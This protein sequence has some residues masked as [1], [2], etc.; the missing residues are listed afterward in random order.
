MACANLALHFRILIMSVMIFAATFCVG[1]TDP[2][3]VAAIN[4]LYVALGS[5]PLQGWK[6]TGGDPCVEQWQGVSCVFSNI[7]ALQ[8]G[9]MNLSGQLGSNL[10]FPSIIEMDI[11][12][13]SIG[14]TI[15]STLPSTLKRLSLSE[16]K[17]NGSIPDALSMLIQLTELS[18]NNNHLTGQIPDVFLQF[19]SLTNMNLS[20]NN[21]SG[22]LPPSIV[23]LSSLTTLHLQN[24]QLGGTLF[25]LEDL[26]L[27]NL[28]IENNL[29]SG[30]IPPK[31]LTIPEFRK[32]GNPFNTTIIHSPPA[33]APSPEAMVPSPSP[34]PSTEKSHGKGA[35]SPSM[36][37]KAP[38]PLITRSSFEVKNMVWWIAGF[39]II[40]FIALGICLFMCW[41][42]KRRPRSKNY[43]EHK[44]MD[45]YI[46]EEKGQGSKLPPLQQALPHPLPII[47]GE[48]FISPAKSTK[49]IEGGKQII[50]S[51]IRVYSVALLQQYTDSFSQE[52]YIGEGTLGP[53]YKG[54]LP[55]GKLLAVRKLNA[56]MVQNHEQ[57]LQLVFSISKIQHPNIVKLLGYCTEH[58]QWLLVYEYCSNGTLHDALHTDDNT[59]VKLSWNERIQVSL[60]AARA[61]QYLHENFQPPV[62]QRNFRSSNVLLNDK[63][64]VCVSDCGLGSLLSSEQVV[65]AQGY[66]APEF[67]SGSYTQKSDVFSFGVVMLELLTGRKAFD[68]WRP[69][70]EQSVVRW[71][72]P[73]LHD[74]DALS[75]M[76]DPSLNGAYPPPPMKS[77]SRFADV[78]SSCLQHEPEFR[79]AMSEIVQDLLRI[80][81]SLG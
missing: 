5:P 22:Q 61:L 29:F 12:N 76:V 19:T 81:S 30:P 31:L 71:A 43:E 53:L 35:K 15:P 59:R 74:I 46:D 28:N 60:G 69:R 8:L 26:P 65:T 23:N 48:N 18:L 63:M 25:V 54:E 10:D 13:N 73:Q 77:L 36:T 78:I 40:I 27:Q 24:N 38:T 68:R 37:M 11:S 42:C 72:V 79:P 41:Y 70:G 39:G 16:N 3:D 7:T 80:T 45:V 64:E 62:V 21:L 75:E 20:G 58:S 66:D 14:G 6:P 2:L 55:D 17:L 67:E 34:T 9:S 32:D 50:T 51:S 49:V 4:S 47:S 44:D 1:D 56:S 52:N 57:F 33:A